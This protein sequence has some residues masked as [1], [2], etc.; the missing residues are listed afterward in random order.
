MERQ[1][2]MSIDAAPDARRLRASHAESPAAPKR[3]R[4]PEKSRHRILKA[5]TDEFCAHGFNGARVER[6]ARK[7]GANMRMLYHYFGSKEGLYLA[8]LDKVYSEIRLEERKLNLA[9]LDPVAGMRELVR[10]TFDF[11]ATH[12][13]FVGLIN[14]ENLMKGRFLKKSPRIRDMTVPLVETIED[15]LKRGV[16][17][18]L[19]RAGVDP[20]QLYISI[21]AQSQLHISNRYTLSAIFDRDLG[22]RD[23]LEE[24]RSHAQELILGYLACGQP[25]RPGA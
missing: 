2:A 9:T 19:M 11:F 25:R 17:A 23:W 13:D 21:V 24:R 10:F 3:Q 16:A 15:L 20:I 4:D 18:G 22:D 7:S 5:A 1:R 8:A 14:N 6:I 12:P